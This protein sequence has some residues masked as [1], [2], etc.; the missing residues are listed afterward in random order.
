M[1]R[2]TLARI[3]VL[4]WFAFLVRGKTVEKDGLPR[5]NFSIKTFH[6]LSVRRKQH[7]GLSG[8]EN[9]AP[10]PSWRKKN[11]HVYPTSWL[12]ADS[13]PPVPTC[14]R[15]RTP[16]EHHRLQDYCPQPM[17]FLPFVAPP[18][19][20]TFTDFHSGNPLKLSILQAKTDIRYDARTG[21]SQLNLVRRLHFLR[22]K[23]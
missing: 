2:L 12:R 16:R 18:S 22:K 17:T 20:N 10:P 19:V 1:A 4:F 15:P 21:F 6:P 5:Q 13:A 23:L 9:I 11:I 8:G 3:D 7:I 14:I